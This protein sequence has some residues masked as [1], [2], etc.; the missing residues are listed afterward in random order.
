MN[1]GESNLQRSGIFRYGRLYAAL[2]K[3][4]VAREMSFKG[5]F[6]LWI[7]V[8]LLWFGLQLSFIGV[9]FSQTDSIGSWTKWQMV[10]LVGASNFIQQIYQAFFLTNCTGLSE[11][12]RTGKMD[13]LLALPVNTRFIVS[14]RQVDLGA[15]VNA[16]FGLTVMVFALHKAHAIPSAGQILG[17]GAL[18]LAGILIHYSLMIML[19]A[20]SFWTVRAQGIVWGYYNL[21]NIARLPDEAFQRGAFK[22]IFTFALPV[23]LV[24]NVPTRVIANKLASPTSWLLLIGLGVVWALISEWFWRLSLRRYTSASS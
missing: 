9:V 17:F 1:E 20:I 24:S 23:L 19:A 7:F 13:F 18:C 21:F 2:W 12:V 10:V 11:L 5:N 8:E 22:A 6:I 15:F 14:L 4:S 16:V 3:N